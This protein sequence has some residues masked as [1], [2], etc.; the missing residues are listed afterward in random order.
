ML[1]TQLE[2]ENIIEGLLFLSRNDGI[3]TQEIKR[4]IEENISD[5][6]IELS[7][8]NLAKR[9]EKINSALEIIQTSYSYKLVTNKNYF[10]YFKKYTNKSNSN[11]SMS[12]LET[13]VIIAYKQPITT[14]NIEKIKGVSVGNQL[15]NLKE[16]NLI[17]VS[18]KAEEIGKPNVYSTTNDFLDKLGINTIEELPSL[19]KFAIK[20]EV[21]QTKNISFK[22][23]SKKLLANDNVIEIVDNNEITKEL[24][25]VEEIAE[26]IGE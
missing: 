18:G 5:E 9:Y 23:L 17:Y 1:L 22:E 20:E 14:F 24:N 3:T 15:T 2:L 4:I 8:S 25:A 21:N 7:I 10:D 13:L 11:L 26:N 16:K 6:Q 19:K 12:T